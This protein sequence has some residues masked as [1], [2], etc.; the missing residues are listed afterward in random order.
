[1]NIIINP[2]DRLN[3]TVAAPPSKSYSHRAFIASSLADGIS[4]IKNALV[5]GDVDVT[6][7]VLQNLGIN[8]S[9]ISTN[10]FIVK[11]SG[12]LFKPFNG[13][14]DCRNSGTSLRI[15]SML[16]LLVK[17]GL[18]FT[19]SFLS[20]KR[21]I[22]PLLEAI[23]KLGGKCVL[24]SNSLSVRRAKNRCNT[25]EIRGD[26]SSQFI[27]ALLM[28]GPLLSCKK[29]DY[30]SVNIISPLKSYPYV[31]ITLK[32]LKYFGIN[33]QEKLD[34]K[35]LGTYIIPCYQNYR[36]QRFNVPGDFS[37]ISYIITAGVLTPLDS[38]ITITNLDFND[39]QG[40]KQIIEILKDMGAKIE[41]DKEKGQ[42]VIEGNLIKYP[43]K[44]KR[45]DVKDIPDLFPILAV[46][47]AFAHD[48]TILDNAINLRYKESDRITIMSRELSKMGIKVEESEEQLIIYHCDQLKA[49]KV[50]HENDHR[51]A[52][53]LTIANLFT[54]TSSR[55][56]NI[57][58]VKDS[59]PS[60]IEDLVR[61][62]AQISRE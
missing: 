47:G 25:I 1:M 24:N 5:S 6:I 46:I 49:A 36:A 53:A 19:G 38:K 34:E 15:F 30:F 35:R 41:I 44:G 28:I 7:K 26:I 43:L 11:G 59:Y 17:G 52:M 56:N 48:K 51:I 20:R 16:A 58:I 10:Q 21:P 18:N 39:P 9:K 27:T 14:I 61:L 2:T 13:I 57:E 40:D 37:S 62:G 12:G 29:K 22:S 31:L 23:T 50:L 3:G 45:I 8:I 33:I 42:V 60:F 4:V 32:V 54:E 55:I